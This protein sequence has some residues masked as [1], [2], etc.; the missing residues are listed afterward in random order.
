MTTYTNIPDSSIEPD[1]PITANLVAAL[2]D[3]PIAMGEADPSVPL[4]LLPTVLLGTLN[5]TSGSSQT[6]SGLALTPYRLVQC[7]CRNLNFNTSSYLTFAGQ[8]VSMSGVGV[9]GVIML[10][11]STGYAFAQFALISAPASELR[12]VTTGYSTAT[13]SLVFA[14]SSASF[15]SGTITIYGQK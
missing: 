3:D 7:L 15:N 8:Q 14:L 13:T 9:T 12:T 2:R 5:T 10:D 4:N 1:D 6:L 11:L